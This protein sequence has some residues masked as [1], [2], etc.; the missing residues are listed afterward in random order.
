MS[1]LLYLETEIELAGEMRLCSVS[2]TLSDGEIDV[3][4]VIACRRFQAW[5]TSLG[6]FE[7]REERVDVDVTALLS[8]EQLQGFELEIAESLIEETA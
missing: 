4:K 8:A 1:A 7:P 2:Y 5:Y 6:E 3:F